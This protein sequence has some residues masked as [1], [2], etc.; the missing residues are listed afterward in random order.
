MNSTAR[1]PPVRRVAMMACSRRSMNT[2]RLGKPVS[3]SC[4]AMCA[5]RLRL[6]SSSRSVELMREHISAKPRASSPISSWRRVGSS[7]SACS[8]EKRFISRVICCSGRVTSRAANIASTI[9][10][11]LKATTICTVVRPRMR[12]DSRISDSGSAMPSRK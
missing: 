11:A 9:A 7:P 3:V 2:A 10:M 12:V 5:I 6:A 1:Q 4:R 8:L